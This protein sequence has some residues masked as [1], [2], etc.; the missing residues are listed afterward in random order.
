MVSLG[1]GSTHGGFS[2]SM[3]A[4]RRANH[5]W[6]IR[7]VMIFGRMLN[8]SILGWNCETAF[9]DKPTYHLGT[10]DGKS[11]KKRD[12]EKGQGS[13]KLLNHLIPIDRHFQGKIIGTSRA[14][15]I[16][17]Q[18]CGR[19]GWHLA[20]DVGDLWAR[21]RQVDAKLL[22]L[23]DHGGLYI[24]T[25]THIYIYYMYIHMCIIYI[26]NYKCTFLYTTKYRLE[27]VITHELGIPFL[28]VW[29]LEDC[30]HDVMRT[31]THTYIY[32]L[33]IYIYICTWND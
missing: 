31:H 33:Y 24:C 15:S 3:L 11:L 4:Y 12:H 21:T 26:Y 19:G 30:S 1:K 2:K 9:S 32:I 16:Q 20:V 25:H 5:S 14:T 22:L 7:F 29:G 23:D 8:F 27:I 28:T 17:P 18:L 6:T 13:T 10:R